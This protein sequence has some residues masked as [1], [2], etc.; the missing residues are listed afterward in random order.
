MESAQ[1]LAVLRFEGRRF[2]HHTLD[3]ECTAELLAYRQLVL[4][5][6][7]ELWRVDHP[8]RVRLPKRFDE[9]LRLAVD[10]IDEG[11]ASVPLLR[12]VEDVAPAAEQLVL[13]EFE[14]PYAGDVFDRAARMIDETIAAAGSG[15]LLPTALPPNVIPLFAE[16]GRSL[17]EDE[18][19]HIRATGRLSEVPY[20]HAVRRRLAA[21][22]P[23]T[24]E[25]QVDVVGEVRMASVGPG[26]FILHQGE[27]WPQVEGRFAPEHE[28]IVLDALRQ[29]REVR[30]RI[31]GIAEFSVHDR[32][33]RRLARIDDLEL[34]PALGGGYDDSAPPIWEQLAALGRSDPD[35]WEGLPKDLSM[36][37]DDVV[38]A[39]KGDVES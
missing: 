12:V 32:Q 27:G 6:A 29:H 25:D 7:R 18:V 3:I 28:T 9:G 5:C 17:R 19:L 22:Q 21:W 36:R 16:L 31:K 20:T 11:S 8:G 24:Y 13:E 23:P 39:R 33:M 14:A 1:H 26:R 37:I 38:Y 34:N 15:D 4:E 2:E 35:A 10:R 30:L